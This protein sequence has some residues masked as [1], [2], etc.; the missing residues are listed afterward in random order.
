MITLLL[1][2]L[3]TSFGVWYGICFD[4]N[5]EQSDDDT[6]SSSSTEFSTDMESDG[7]AEP[8]INLRRPC[9]V[10]I[11]LCFP[12]LLVLAWQLSIL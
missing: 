10:V 6:L 7:M 3:Q 9:F 5:R 2:M 12:V 1:N 4:R 8:L 11:E